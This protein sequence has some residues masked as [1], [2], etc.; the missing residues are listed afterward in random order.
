MANIKICDLSIADLD[1]LH[2]LSDEEALA[3]LGGSWF[4]KAWS[5]IRKFLSQNPIK[6]PGS[7][8]KIGSSGADQRLPGDFGI[9]YSGNW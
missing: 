7:G 4:T 3:L 1:M 9:S 8:I 2:E 5:S 6:I